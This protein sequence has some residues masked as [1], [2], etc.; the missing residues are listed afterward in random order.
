MHSLYG[1]R[2]RLDRG[3]TCA[4]SSAGGV[5]GSQ[6]ATARNWTIGRRAAATSTLCVSVPF[7]AAGT[8]GAILAVGRSGWLPRPEDDLGRGA[9][10]FVES[11]EHRLGDELGTAAQRLPGELA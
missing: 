9:V 8:G 11:E 6:S 5:N 2:N 1:R 3:H 4:R 7:R 10:P